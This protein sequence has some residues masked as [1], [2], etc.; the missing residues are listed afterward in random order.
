MT[1]VPGISPLT[2]PAVT[3]ATDVLLLLHVPPDVGS[4]SDVDIP[5]QVL[6]VPEIDD[7]NG[8]TVN[9]VSAVHPVPI[10]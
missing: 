8:L 1:D 7:G 2:I 4:V 5:I 9:V 10:V 6:G 3:V